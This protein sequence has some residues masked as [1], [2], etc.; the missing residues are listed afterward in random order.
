VYVCARVFYMQ[1]YIHNFNMSWWT[2]NICQRKLEY[3]LAHPSWPQLQG[4][5]LKLITTS[6]VGNLSNVT[7]FFGDW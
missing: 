4:K 7:G 5:L 6:L 2:S 3:L 1:D